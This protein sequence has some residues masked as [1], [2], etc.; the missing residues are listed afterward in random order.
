[1]TMCRVEARQRARN[2]IEA[3][4]GCP[5][6][7]GVDLVAPSVDPTDKWTLEIALETDGLPA[8]VNAILGQ[9][10]LWTRYAR[11]RGSGWHAVTV[12]EG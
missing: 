5:A 10:G 3:L 12:V 1:M 9:H 7:I 2:A 4:E 6:V 11:P 8:A